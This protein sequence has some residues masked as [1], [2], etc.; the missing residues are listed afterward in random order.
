ML[1]SL[2]PTIGVEIKKEKK[3]KKEQQRHLY[4][5]NMVIARVKEGNKNH[6]F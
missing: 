6:K 1:D 4:T 2:D 3:K 5:R